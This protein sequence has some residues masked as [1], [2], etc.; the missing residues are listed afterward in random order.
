[1]LICLRKAK[2]E[3]NRESCEAGYF[4]TGTNHQEDWNALAW[5]YQNDLG[6]VKRFVLTFI[7]G[8]IIL[9]NGFSKGKPF[10]TVLWEFYLMSQQERPVKGTRASPEL[11]NFL[12]S[13][14]TGSNSGIIA[15]SF[16]SMMSLVG[17]QLGVWFFSLN[18]LVWEFSQGRRDP[19]CCCRWRNPWLKT[20][21]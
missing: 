16:H 10:L 19:R 2:M 20:H 13:A 17:F 11:L 1:M 6:K 21:K 12:Y 7:R 18:F 3:F 5:H 14:V 15:N 4:V 8:W 9:L